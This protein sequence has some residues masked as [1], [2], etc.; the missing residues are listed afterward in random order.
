[1]CVCVCRGGG[2]G[3]GGGVG[4]CARMYDSVN[5]NYYSCNYLTTIIIII[6]LPLSLSYCLSLEYH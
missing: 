5:Y 2:G 4:R 6:V 3:G 1:M